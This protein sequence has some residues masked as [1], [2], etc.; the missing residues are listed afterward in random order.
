MKILKVVGIALLGL[1]LVIF[2]GI[3]Y[4]KASAKSLLDKDYVVKV[5]PIPIPY[6]LTPDEVAKLPEDKRDPASVQAVALERALARGKH[7]IESRA[8]CPDCHG[9]DFG[10]KVIVENPAMGRWIAPNITRGGKTKNYRS[11]DWDR[12]VRHGV[13]PSGKPAVM[14]ATDFAG[15]SD[16]EVSDIAAYISSLPPVER[17][18]PKSELG[19]IYSFLIA[20]GKLPLSAD[21]IQHAAARPALPPVIA[22][23]QELG[24]HLTATCMGCHGEGLSGGKIEAGDPAWPPAKNL[25]FDDT[26][27]AKWSQDDFRKALKEGVRP[28]GSKINPVMPIAYTS[29][30]APEE[31]DALY[32]YLKTVP[33]RAYGNH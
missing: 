30:L 14:P 17:E 2:G 3:F 11:E 23:S 1:L 6:A 27:L 18:M 21:V 15:F 7:Y 19:P 20:S 31:V 29:K 26:G 9:H 22:A 5:A 13:L 4:F 32:M 33:K 28:D 10:G 8:G 25:T 16:Q 12:V 24:K